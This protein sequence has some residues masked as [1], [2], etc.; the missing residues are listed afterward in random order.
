MTR[1]FILFF[2][3]S[4]TFLTFAQSI[5]DAAVPITLTVGVNP[6]GVILNWQNGSATDLIL[7]R[8]IKGQAGNIWTN[9]LDQSGNLQNGYFDSGLSA[10]ETYEYEVALNKGSFTALGNAFAA[11]N[12]SPID[13]RGKLLVFIDSTTADQL[14]MDLVLY[15]NE[16]RSEGWQ[17][18]PFKTGDFTTVA[19]VK[20]KIVAAYNAEPD[21]V[22]AVLLMGTVPVPYAGSTARDNRNDHI[23]AWPCDA[24][25]GDV[26]G[27]W[28]DN[29][30]NIPNTPRVANRNVPGD[31]KFDQNTLPSEIELPIGRLDFRR[32]S[33]ATFGLSPVELLRRYLL[34]NRQWRTGKYKVPVRALIDDQLGWANGEAFASDGY[35]NAYPLVGENQVVQ[36]EFIS[37]SR[38]LMG[39]GSGVG[40]TYSSAPGIGTAYSFATDS[41]HV[42]FAQMFGDYIGDWDYETDPLMPA[43]LASKGGLLACVWAGRPHWQM[44]GLAIGETIGYC[45]KETQNAQYNLGYGNSN[46]ESGTHIALLGDPT[47]R[48]QVIAPISNLNTFSNCNKVNLNWIASPEPDI[49]GY[50]VYRAFNSNGPYT[51]VSQDI[52]PFQTSWIDL[53]P[54]AD[55]LYYVVRTIKASAQPGAATY[56]NASTSEIKSVIF[57]SGTAPTVIGLGGIIKCNNPVITMGASF[58]PPTCIYEW[59]KPNGSA[60]GGYFATEPGTYTVRVTAP[61]GCT[62]VANASVLIDTML[63]AIDIPSMVILDCNNPAPTYT[64]PDAPNGVTYTFNGAIVSG[65]T[66][67]NIASNGTL[68]VASSVNGC[69]KTYNFQVFQDFALPGAMATSDGNNLDCNHPTVQLFGNANAPNASFAWSANGSIILEQNP[70]IDS[71]GTYCLVVT[72]GNGCTSSHC[73]TITA[74]GSVVNTDIISDAIPCSVGNNINL[75]A[76]VTGGT[77]QFQYLWSNGATDQ[78]IQLTSSF[79]G[80]IS[81]LITDAIGC[82]GSASVNITASLEAVALA[83]TPSSSVATDGSIDLIV[84][85]GASP[86]TFAWS[87]GSTTQNQE[88]LTSN[89]YTVIVT[90]SDGCTTMVTVPLITIGSTDLW[91][92]GNIKISPNPAHDLIQVVLNH[93]RLEN[94]VVCL[95]DINNRVILTQRAESKICTFQVSELPTG[96]YIIEIETVVG[97]KMYRVVVSH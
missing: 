44:Q 25:Y 65:G 90:G 73:I 61:N 1:L 82:W 85:G 80:T 53:S 14:G 69:S 60:L 15:K 50:L 45:L 24:Y 83:N 16:L 7:R 59:F 18:E 95:K 66:V 9:L 72:G 27:I 34:K 67:I 38:Y 21:Q 64:L 56:F 49:H 91:A 75:T 89:I 11:F 13:S 87:N 23:G 88:G 28:T 22:K 12:A 8:R 74:N 36:G 78:Q 46:S 3:L 31:G 41:A 76:L 70:V 35:R 32:V 39:Y 54:V 84:I 58:Q 6:P 62:A 33:M 17:I 96:V 43:A 94:A 48:A 42:V 5:Q 52:L 2:C 81:V 37:S 10:F 79:S 86:Y 68:V 20:N 47:L 51:R 77:A 92:A 63:P 40:G 97:R 30:V 29:T 93:V 4:G 26:D 55:T 19:W 71:A 57:V